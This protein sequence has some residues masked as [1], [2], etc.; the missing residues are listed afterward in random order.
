MRPERD[1]RS[2]QNTTAA[3]DEGR[4]PRSAEGARFASHLC[5]GVGGFW[6]AI[7]GCVTGFSLLDSLNTGGERRRLQPFFVLGSVNN[8]TLKR[9]VVANRAQHREREG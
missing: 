5:G 3:T 8:R 6:L 7:L 4:M 9:D 1:E 2:H